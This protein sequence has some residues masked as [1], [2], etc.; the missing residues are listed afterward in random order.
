MALERMQTSPAECVFV[1]DEPSWDIAGATK[2][3]TDAV[4]IDRTG[5]HAGHT[6]C[7]VIASLAELTVSG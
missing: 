2:A 1:G 6:D 5:K 4:L 3:G 7:I